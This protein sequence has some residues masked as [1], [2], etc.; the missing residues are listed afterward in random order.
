M[1]IIVRLPDPHCGH[2]L[3]LSLLGATDSELRPFRDAV[4]T[5]KI[6]KPAAGPQ[7]CCCRWVVVGCL[8]CGWMRTSHGW[9]GAD[10]MLGSSKNSVGEESRKDDGL[11][12]LSSTTDK[13]VY[14]ILYSN[15]STPK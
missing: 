8:N 14:S 1:S 11:G 5:S 6:A 9:C 10:G 13:N 12:F 15:N 4:S 2:P 3:L 7:A